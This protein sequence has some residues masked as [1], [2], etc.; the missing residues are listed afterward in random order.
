MLN[1]MKNSDRQNAK[2][3]LDKKLQE[4][5]QN[6]MFTHTEIFKKFVDDDS[7]QKRYQEFIF[8]VMWEHKGQA[9]RQST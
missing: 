6:M 8:D 5:M 1:T 7:F 9:S 2:I 3:A 4:V